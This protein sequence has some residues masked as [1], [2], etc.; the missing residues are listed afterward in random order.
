MEFISNDGGETYNNCH[1]VS[2]SNRPILV[3]TDDKAVLLVVL[4]HEAERIGVDITVELNAR[5]LPPY[6][7]L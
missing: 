5:E 2:T 7:P 4:L 3:Q 1:F 6:V